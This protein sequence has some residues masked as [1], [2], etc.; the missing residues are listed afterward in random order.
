[1]KLISKIFIYLLL[2]S[3]TLCNIDFTSLLSG[4]DSTELCEKESKEEKEKEEER[5]KNCEIIQTFAHLLND[6]KDY[7]TNY[8]TNPMFQFLKF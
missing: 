6:V 7:P 3:Y 2:C 4:K 8:S 1:M 5:E